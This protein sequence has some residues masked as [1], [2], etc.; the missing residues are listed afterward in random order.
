MA[1]SAAQRVFNVTELCEKILIQVN[2]DNTVETLFAIQRVSTTFRDV[3]QGSSAL[4]I[5]L[6]LQHEHDY[7]SGPNAASAAMRALKHR[8]SISPFYASEAK[9]DGAAAQ[10]WP[11]TVRCSPRA[12]GVHRHE[13]WG[14][15]IDTEGWDETI[16]LS[17][18]QSTHA[19]E[20]A[21][22]RDVKLLSRPTSLIILI[23]V[24]IGNVSNY[25]LPPHY[26]VAL[27]R[28][29]QE[30]AEQHLSRKNARENSTWDS[31]MPPRY[32][33]K[34]L[35]TAEQA[36][37]GNLVTTLAGIQSRSGAEHDKLSRVSELGV[38]HFEGPGHMDGGREDED[39]QQEW[40]GM[41]GW[42]ARNHRLLRSDEVD[43]LSEEFRLAVAVS[44][45][46]E[47]S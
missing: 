20:R 21:S 2:G 27:S 17:G 24:R 41:R 14:F 7:A 25:E 8:L 19:S 15:R 42:I 9:T 4:R 47:D 1:P 46:V 29:Q 45:S 10:I 13:T 11:M 6:G 38:R 30:A 33:D 34:I 37:L 44:M 39:A 35:F 3:V 28:F 43:D 18:A 26:L 16:G 23:A 12:E 31:P 32:I 40:P 5:K 36:T 22:W